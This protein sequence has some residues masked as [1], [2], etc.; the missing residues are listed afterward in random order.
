MKKKVSLFQSAS[1]PDPEENLL[2]AE[3][4]AKEAAEFGALMLVFPECFMCYFEKGQSRE[5]KSRIVRE[6]H[7]RFVSAMR[8]LGKKYGFWMVFGTYEPSE[9]PSEIRCYNTVYMTDGSGE[10]VLKYRKTHLYD[11][12]RNRESDFV[13]PGDRLCEVLETPL[14]KTAVLTCYEMRFPE[15][16]RKLVTDGADVL[17]HPT[18]WVGGKLKEE[19]YKVLCRAR[20]MENTVYFLSAD[21]CDKVHSGSSCIVD[22]MGVILCA[23]AESETLLN[24]E[25]D[26]E[27]I[28]SAREIMPVLSGRRPELFTSR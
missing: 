24:G 8:A 18:A 22:P 3:K 25:I 15:I 21:Q 4:A 12:F 28:A 6:N 1:T 26:P 7:D 10:I 17:L 19:Q 13:I 23:A 20:A 16:A 5:E 11:A 9:D 27:R 2:K 14:G